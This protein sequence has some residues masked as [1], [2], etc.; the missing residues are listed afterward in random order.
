MNNQDNVK[1]VKD[2]NEKDNN[3]KD[4]TLWTTIM[5]VEKDRKESEE[6]N[7]LP[8]FVE[9]NDGGININKNY[10]F[11][12]DEKGLGYY[13]EE[14][15]KYPYQSPSN[16]IVQEFLDKY[17]LFWQYPVVTE[18]YFFL[19]NNDNQDYFGFPW[20]T[21][22][23]KRYDLNLIYKLINDHFNLDT[24]K[25]YF[26]CIQH[27]SFRKLIPLLKKLNI[28]LIYSPHKVLKED[29]ID[30]IK[31]SPCPLYA[32]NYESD[33]CA[34]L[35]RCSDKQTH[36]ISNY[37]LVHKDRSILFSF[38][39]AYNPRD[40]LTS[41]R[42]D[43]FNMNYGNAKCF[44]KNT[45]S[46]HF[47]SLVYS[48]YQNYSRSFNG[49]EKTKIKTNS[50]M[51]NFIML[52]SRYSLCPSGSG[53]NSIRFW[54]SLAY[55]SIPILLADTLELPKHELWE[56]AI[57]RIPE[58]NLETIPSVLEKITSEE[59]TEMRKNC[60]TIYHHFRLNYMNNP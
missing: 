47:D 7:S 12:R 58:K 20:A 15:F 3:E 31:I 8:D 44:I 54:E 52:D 25:S 6:Y 33:E 17:K 32:I 22:I 50:T 51:Y 53:P 11:K 42:D 5:D 24:N 10:V 60:I 49:A 57:I 28:N 4:N 45:G 56:K 23:D 34:K 13:K 55:G 37:D 29:E 46:W 14:F 2:N 36:I 30:D 59:E 35:L 1:I 16:H 43:I 41:I 48:K 27:I 26:T 39:G 9:A 40:Y 38:M 19:Q 21:I 18:Q